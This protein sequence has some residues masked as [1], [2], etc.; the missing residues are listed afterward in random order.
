VNELALIAT[1][2]VCLTVLAYHALKLHHQRCLRAELVKEREADAAHA[3]EMETTL[4]LVRQVRDQ[5]FDSKLEAERHAGAA[6]KA[7]ADFDAVVAGLNTNFETVE[8]N[9]KATNGR[10]QA[11]EVALG[12]GGG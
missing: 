12:W 4:N 3:A 11:C 5:V 10:V 2:L 8:T 6:K 9:F 7:K 1:A